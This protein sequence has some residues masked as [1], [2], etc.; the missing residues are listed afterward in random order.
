MQK[1]KLKNSSQFIAQLAL[2]SPVE[3]DKKR[4]EAA[5][6]MKIR[7]STLDREVEKLRQTNNQQQS[8]FEETEPWPEKVNGAVLLNEIREVINDHL[9]I[10]KWVDIATS[11]W[12]VLT[13]CFSSMRILPL[14]GVTSPEK[15]CGKT[16]FAEVLQGL[17]LNAVIASNISSAVL[18]RLIEKYK[19]TLLVDEA[20][21]F[22]VDNDELR[23]VFNAG[24]TKKS[25]F[26]W[27]VNT[28]TLEPEKF[29]VWGPKVVLM[30]GNLP[31]TMEDRSIRV[32]MRRKAPG[33]SVKKLTLDFEEEQLHIRRKCMRWCTDNSLLNADPKIPNVGNDRASDNWLPLLAIA[34]KAGGDWPELARAAMVALEH[35]EFD[36]AD[37][38]GQMLLADIKK[39]FEKTECEQ[40]FSKNLVEHLIQ[41]EDRPWFEWRCGNPLT[42]NTLSKILKPFG[43]RSKQIRISGKKQRGYTVKNFHDSFKRYL[44]ARETLFQSGTSVHFN[45]SSKLCKEESGTVKEGVPLKKT[46]NTLNSRGCTTV[47]LQKTG[48]SKK[49]HAEGEDTGRT[50]EQQAGKKQKNPEDTIT[51]SV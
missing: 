13:Y 46:L 34:D 51:V 12:V 26:V 50:V 27:R 21:T 32:G 45:N 1:E 41:L 15:R 8:L 17:V 30:I 37:S 33:E 11:L 25:A 36:E 2:L 20:D 16:T 42:Q 47:P 40:I 31:G 48:W 6:T 10:P 9:I 44:S 19:P 49:E 5:E 3:Y 43:I 28:E 14:L 22:L 7:V 4:V 35:D 23:G 29:S 18:Y 39:I 38:V 24:H